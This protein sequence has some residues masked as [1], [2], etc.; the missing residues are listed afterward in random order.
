[1]YPQRAR[2][3]ITP[4]ECLHGVMRSMIH[5]SKL[6]QRS[7]LMAIFKAVLVPAVRTR[8]LRL[9]P[10]KTLEATSVLAASPP[11]VVFVPWT[12]PAGGAGG[13]GGGAGGA[14]GG[15]GASSS[16]AVPS[17]APVP[18]GKK[19]AAAEQEAVRGAS[20]QALYLDGDWQLDE[21]VDEAVASVVDAA[22]APRTNEM[23]AQL[24]K[25]PG[26]LGFASA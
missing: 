26:K 10:V 12:P 25:L 5:D 16:V 4:I 15:A 17:A 9:D 3:G 24:D 13:A 7:A 20:D 14:A 18:K 2:G 23:L 1:M 11:A 6:R 19:A 22:I 21:V 8:A